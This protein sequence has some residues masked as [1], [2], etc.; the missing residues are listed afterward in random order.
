[1]GTIGYVAPLLANVADEDSY[2]LVVENRT[3]SVENSALVSQVQQ[4]GE[5]ARELEEET[6]RIATEL[7]NQ[8]G[9]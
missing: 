9:K 3:L 2:R 6:S 1:M 5:R 4:L 7:Q 8:Q